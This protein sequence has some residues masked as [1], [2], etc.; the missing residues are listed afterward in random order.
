VFLEN[1]KSR[2]SVSLVWTKKKKKSDD[3]PSRENEVYALS[4]RVIYNLPI[5]ARKEKIR[6]KKNKPQS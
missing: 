6:N 2:G 4:K 1:Q 5:L 3:I